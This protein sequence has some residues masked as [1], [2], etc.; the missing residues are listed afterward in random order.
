MDK[1]SFNQLMT[2]LRPKLYRFA[3]AFVGR[4][5]EAEDVV[6][7]IG[8]KLWERRGELDALRSVEAYAMSAVRN[9]C[10]DYARSPHSRTDEWIEAHDAAHEQTPYKS[11][12][13]SDMAAFVRRLIDRLPE[14]QQMVIRLRD[15]EGYELE[16]I[17]E[18]LGMN[19]G[20]VRTSLSR[21]RQKIREELLKQ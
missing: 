9:R 15:I 20:T 11:V 6:Q 8:I 3:L 21:A 2:H 13:Q 10:L 18:I 7:E 1:T 12:E 16:E 19:G 14:Q 5:D 17:A 4:T